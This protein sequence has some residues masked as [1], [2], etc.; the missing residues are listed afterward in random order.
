M[1]QICKICGRKTHEIFQTKFKIKYHY[2]DYCGFISKDKND[3][4]TRDEEIKIYNNHNN[5]IEDPRYVAFFKGFLD[6][7]V[8]RFCDGKKGLDFGSGPSPV[9]AMILERDYGFSMDIYDLYYSPEKVFEGKT[10]DLITSTE[11]IEH[12][13]NPL[14]YFRLFKEHMKP[15]GILSIMTLFHPKDENEFLNWYYMRDMSHISFFTPK[16]MR[17]IGE[18]VGLEIIYTDNKRYTTYRLL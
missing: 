9:L 17:I 11:V 15:N 18:V 2:C 5:S 10:Y 14:P 8:L 12:L 16:T 1:D 3:L 13:A 6:N 4:I 7:A